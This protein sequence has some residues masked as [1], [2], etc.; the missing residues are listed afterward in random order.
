MASW[1][2]RTG[3]RISGRIAI[4]TAISPVER[5]GLNTPDAAE[6]APEVAF[7]ARIKPSS[8][9]N[10]PNLGIGYFFPSGPNCFRYAGF[11]RYSEIPFGMNR[12]DLVCKRFSIVLSGALSS[13]FECGVGSRPGGSTPLESE[14]SLGSALRASSLVERGAQSACKLQRVIIGPEVHEEKPRLLVEHVAMKRRHL[15]AVRT[16][17]LDDRVHFFAGQHEIAGYRSLAAAGR[18]EAYR[19]RNA[20]RAHGT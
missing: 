14:V 11:D 3:I 9:G 18:L 15:D 7:T 10:I 4:L 12:L 20:K 17:S 16:Q 6:L 13:A 8:G 2:S 1:A 19:G 5:I